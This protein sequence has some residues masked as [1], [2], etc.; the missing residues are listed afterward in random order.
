[1]S[2]E[3]IIADGKMQLM[4]RGKTREQANEAFNEMAIVSLQ[5]LILTRIQEAMDQAIIG[6]HAMLDTTASDYINGLR[7]DMDSYGVP[8]ISID[9]NVAYL[10][11]GYASYDMLPGLLNSKNAKISKDGNRYAIIPIGKSIH[12]SAEDA[13]ASKTAEVIS[14]VSS[15]T[16]DGKKSLDEVVREMHSRITGVSTPSKSI[17]SGTPEF[18]VASSTQQGSG[19]WQHPGFAGVQQLASINATLAADIQDMIMYFVERNY[20]Q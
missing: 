5:Q 11:N 12:G 10:E 16:L 3:D 1:M 18:R 13:G 19:A 8:S 6:A 15:V 9:E 14:A 7:V 4:N 17:T 2:L 20:D